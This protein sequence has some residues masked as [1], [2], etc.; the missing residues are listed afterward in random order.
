MA[1]HKRAKPGQGV[2]SEVKRKEG[3]VLHELWKRRKIRTQAEF[4]AHCGFTQPYL[5]QFFKGLRPLT[6][7]VAE[8]FA[9]ELNVDVSDF[10]PRL[11]HEAI[12]AHIASSWPFVR[13]SRE[14][15]KLLSRGQ[16]FEIESRILREL[17]DSGL[18][19]EHNLRRI[20]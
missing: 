6:V 20:K 14:Q 9:A 2:P 7:D 12:Q 8:R 17:I 1:T 13:V 16:Q 10:S 3:A 18:L 4:A 15:F 19:V 11:A 5:N